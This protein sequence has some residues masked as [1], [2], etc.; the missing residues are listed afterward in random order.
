MFT[1]PWDWWAAPHIQ[2]SCSGG[3]KP[4]RDACSV[5]FFIAIGALSPE[6]AGTFVKAGIVDALYISEF[7]GAALMVIGFMR[8]TAGKE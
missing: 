4:W 8:A 5:T 7:F 3:K 6:M 2:L 1:E